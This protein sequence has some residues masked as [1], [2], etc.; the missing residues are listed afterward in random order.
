M[1]WLVRYFYLAEDFCC[2]FLY[3]HNF[4]FFAKRGIFSLTNRASAVRLFLLLLQ[5]RVF[6]QRR[7]Q[8]SF[9]FVK[10]TGKEVLSG[11]CFYSLGIYKGGP[12]GSSGG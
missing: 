5:G 10:N 9:S 6:V 4:L 2:F 12:F 3:L 11:R 8:L 7:K 1:P